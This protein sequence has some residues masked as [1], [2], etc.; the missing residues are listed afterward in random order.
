MCL[1]RRQLKGSKAST[2]TRMLARPKDV[3]GR[4]FLSLTGFEL[5]IWCSF[6][7]SRL[8]QAVNAH[9]TKKKM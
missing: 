5:M 8:C 7:F 2:C 6:I 3:K 1:I 9:E 4:I